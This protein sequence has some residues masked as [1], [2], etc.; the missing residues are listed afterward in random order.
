MADKVIFLTSGTSW[1]VPNDWN[2]AANT[3]EALGGGSGG[4]NGGVGAGSRGGGGGGGGAYAISTNVA[5]TRGASVFVQV[6]AGGAAASAGTETW[7]NKSSNAIPTLASD[8]AFWRLGASLHLRQPAASAALRLP[9][10]ERLPTAAVMAVVL[11]RRQQP[12][13][14]VVVAAVRLVQMVRARPEVPDERHRERLRVVGLA[15]VAPMAAAPEALARPRLA[16]RAV[17]IV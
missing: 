14:V 9:A 16:V 2:D 10:L 5:L 1:V 8:G 13:A 7:L 11:G 6:G 3:I 15:V 17:I 12:A 4:Q